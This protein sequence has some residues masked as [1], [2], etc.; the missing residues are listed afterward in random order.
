M[1]DPSN[2]ELFDESWGVDALVSPT[3]ALVSLVRQAT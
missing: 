1:N 3:T 2:E